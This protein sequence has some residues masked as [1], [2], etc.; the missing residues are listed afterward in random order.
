MLRLS[1]LAT[2][3]KNDPEGTRQLLTVP[4]LV[5]ESAALGTLTPD[6]ELTA[7]VKEKVAALSTDPVIHF[8]RK[9]PNTGNAF[10]QGI[11]L[12]RLVS[13]DIP[14][15]DNRISRFHAWFQKDER[16]DEWAL[17]DAESRN[18]TWLEERKLA[19]AKREVLTNLARLRFG[20]VEFRFL[21]PTTLQALIATP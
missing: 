10:T 11:T 18:G 19:P 16:L 7:K 17:T 21:L 20:H 6:W 8:L 3:A 1:E 2:A 14:V 15:E 9:V 13:N 12:G 5:A 4:A